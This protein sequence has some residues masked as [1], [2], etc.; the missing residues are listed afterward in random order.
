MSDELPELLVPLG[1][2]IVTR[3]DLADLAGAPR[4]AGAVAI[5]VANPADDER[6]YLARFPDGGEVR[7]ARRQFSI[8]KQS[9]RAVEGL[10]PQPT[11]E[12]A[13]PYLIYRCVVGSRAYGLDNEQSDTDR[14]G[15]FLPPAAW[16][17]SL[18]GVPEQVEDPAAEESYW[19]AQKFLGLALKGNPNILE[20]LYSPLVEHASPLAQELLDQRRIFLSRRIYQSYNGYVLS[21]FKRLEQDLRTAGQIKWKHAMHLV[22]LL[23]SGIAALEEGAV[24]VR[25][26]RDRERLLAIRRGE[27]TWEQVN[28]WRM[29]LHR[30]FD[31][32]FARTSLPEF[33]DYRA[34]DAWLLKARRSMVDG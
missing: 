8:R 19:E 3:L 16:H 13:R 7:L 15:I 31:R 5:V 29:E 23:L 21:Q 27:Q 4:P 25:V 14:R 28:A 17:W 20:C 34:A 2:H 1:T 32:A 33:P 10:P 18:A 22:R 9:A 26:D 6:G 11:L 30:A 24:M 12:R